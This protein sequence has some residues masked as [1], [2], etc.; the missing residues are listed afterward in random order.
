LQI[1]QIIQSF[2]SLATLARTKRLCSLFGKH[3]AEKKRATSHQTHIE[4]RLVPTGAE[5]GGVLAERERNQSGF[6]APSKRE[7][8]YKKNAKIIT[9]A[10][11]EEQ[12]RNLYIRNQKKYRHTQ[13]W[14]VRCLMRKRTRPCSPLFES[15]R[16]VCNYACWIAAWDFYPKE[17][18]PTNIPL[19]LCARRG[20]RLALLQS[21]CHVICIYLHSHRNSRCFRLILGW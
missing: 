18:F 4:E 14:W 17:I 3:A 5:R 8:E 19:Y 9:R 1:S 12:R 6:R 20:V 11:E 2:C 13:C 10:F 7:R 21:F 16:S 15:T